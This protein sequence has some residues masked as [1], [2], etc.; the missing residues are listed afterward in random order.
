MLCDSPPPALNKFIALREFH[1]PQKWSH[2]FSKPVES[3][4]RDLKGLAATTAAQSFKTKTKILSPGF[5]LFRWEVTSATNDCQQS[6]SASAS[7]SVLVSRCSRRSSV[8]SRR[9]RRD[10][11]VAISV[12]SIFFSPEMTIP[13]TKTNRK[14]SNFRRQNL[15]N[16][17]GT[18]H[19]GVCPIKLNSVCRN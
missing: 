9:R 2:L 6:A 12:L 17:L 10:A 3:S 11:S 19:K 7:A 15:I 4:S 8:R 13:E 14:M 18:V 16:E 1:K 5:I